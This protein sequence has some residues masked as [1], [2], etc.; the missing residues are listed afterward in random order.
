MGCGTGFCDGFV[1]RASLNLHIPCIWYILVISLPPEAL[2][3]KVLNQPNVSLLY[4]HS[5]SY[6]VGL[7]SRADPHQVK[8]SIQDRVTAFAGDEEQDAVEV[9]N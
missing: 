8:S 4:V 5:L 3:C 9:F 2:G 6:L 7:E 1:V